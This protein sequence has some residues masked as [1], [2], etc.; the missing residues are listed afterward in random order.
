ML[1]STG[2]LTLL[3]A[4][5][6]PPVVVVQNQVLGEVAIDGKTK[7][8]KTSGVWVDGQYVGYVNELVGD[9]KLLLLPGEHEIAVRQ[10][11][12]IEE[13]REVTVEPGKKTTIAISMRK[14]SS[15]A[16]ATAGGSELEKSDV[17]ERWRRSR[18]LRCSTSRPRFSI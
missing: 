9:K 3:L 4:L 11:G 7:V 13:V 15:E 12:Y 16:P 18:R 6:L 2:T 10:A 1:L 14:D 5:L 17:R 8:E